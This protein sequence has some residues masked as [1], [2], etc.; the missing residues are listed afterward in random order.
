MKIVIA[1]TDRTGELADALRREA[2]VR[3]SDPLYAPLP[4]SLQALSLREARSE[5]DFLDRY[6][7]LARQK[8]H[9]D[10]VRFVPPRRPGLKGTLSWQMRR[11]LWR[12]LRY[13]HDRNIFHQNAVNSHLVAA[14]EF[15]HEELRTLRERVDRLEKRGGPA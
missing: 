5:A 10:T 15:Q 1:G 2:A 12:L 4:K 11:V 9:V 14:M 3:T 6:V 13:Q 8:A 7:T